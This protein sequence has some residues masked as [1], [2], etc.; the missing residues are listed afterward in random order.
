LITVACS[1]SL[2]A[3]PMTDQPLPLQSNTENGERKCPKRD[4]NPQSRCSFDLNCLLL[5][6]WRYS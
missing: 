2:L 3:P 1:D 4:L 5:F 6:H